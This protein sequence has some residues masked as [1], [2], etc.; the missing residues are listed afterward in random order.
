MKKLILVPAKWSLDET[1]TLPTQAYLPKI[2]LL[3]FGY[4]TIYAHP[5]MLRAR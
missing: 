1:E 2:L 3:F 4:S 5:C